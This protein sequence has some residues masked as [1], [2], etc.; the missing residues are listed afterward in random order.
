MRALRLC[1]LVLLLAAACGDRDDA[2]P[3]DAA[4]G[5]GATDAASDGAT[6]ARCGGFAGLTCAADQFCDFA[7]NTCGATDEEGECKPRPTACPDTLVFQANCA[8]DGM[9]YGSECDVYAAGSDRNALGGCP[10]A[11]GSFACGY[12]QCNVFNEYCRREVSDIGD[13]PDVFSCQP[14]PGCPS[15]FPTCACLAGELCGSQ[16][17]GQGTTGLTLTCPGG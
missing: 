2:P 5:D 8:C 17:T 14:L 7:R 12:T 10:V 15:Q 3:V 13:E 6:G 4:P 9:I 11:G 16:C 1:P